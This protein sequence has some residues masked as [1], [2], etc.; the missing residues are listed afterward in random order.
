MEVKLE[1]KTLI[2]SETDEKG[3]IIYANDDF[4][5]IAGY[6]KDELIGKPHN[7]VRHPDMPKWAFKNLWDTIQAGKVWRGVVKNKTKD[8]G[9]YWVYAT[10]YPSKDANGNLRYISVRVKPTQEEIEQAKKIIG[11]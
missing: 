1:P 7:I 5:K 10:I 3:R 6:T 9:Y 11:A 4:C 2:V 8:G